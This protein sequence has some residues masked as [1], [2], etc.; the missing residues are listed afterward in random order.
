MN[1]LQKLAVTTAGTLAIS[2]SNAFAASEVQA[3]VFTGSFRLTTTSG[4]SSTLLDLGDTVD[5]TFSYDDSLIPASGLFSQSLLSLSLFEPGSLFSTFTPI[6]T[7]VAVFNN[8]SFTGLR[9]IAIEIS[10][11]GISTSLGISGNA[12]IVSSRGGGSASGS[13]TYSA[14]APA[15]SSIPEPSATIGL[16]LLG[17]W[18]LRKKTLP[19]RRD[20]CLNTSI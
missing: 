5:G 4:D 17:G 8:G 3:A 20:R 19:S 12:F 9:I 15:S 16:L 11:F 1:N 2:L 10:P 18:L 6:D 7:P 14:P 13:V